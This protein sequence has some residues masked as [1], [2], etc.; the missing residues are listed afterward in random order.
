MGPLFPLLMMG[1]TV[2][3]VDLDKRPQLWSR[4]IKIARRSPGT[5]IIPVRKSLPGVQLTSSSDSAIADAAGCNLLEDTP[6]IADW[7]CSPAVAQGLALCIGTLAYADGAL[8][9]SINMAQDAIATEV[10]RRRR[11][12]S[13]ALLLTPTDIYLRPLA[14]RAM[15]TERWENRGLWMRAANLVSGVCTQNV[16]WDKPRVSADGVALDI[17]ECTVPTQGP[18]YLLAKRLQQWRAVVARAQGTVVSASVAPASATASVT[19]QKLLK[20]A[21]GAICFCLHLCACIC[22]K[23]FSG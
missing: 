13:L 21:Y 4:L 18:N 3:A 6:E 7:L 15:A 17:V 5:L 16:F 14:A 20:A 10:C 1:A 11:G 2:V 12:T 9:V 19:K 23:T 8:F 22:C